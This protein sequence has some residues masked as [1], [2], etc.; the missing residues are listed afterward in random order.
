MWRRVVKRIPITTD[1]LEATHWYLN[2]AISRR[3]PFWA[4]L[5]LLFQAIA[6]KTIH[7]EKAIVHDF[8]TSLKRSKSRS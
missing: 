1:S 6:D 5:A 3:N 2:E 8:R 7:F 4:S